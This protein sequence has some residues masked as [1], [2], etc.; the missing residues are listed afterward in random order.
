MKKAMLAVSFMVLC[1]GA[2]FAAETKIERANCDITLGR[3]FP[4]AKGTLNA[5]DDGNV[6]FDYDFANGGRYVGVEIKLPAANMKEFSINFE[7]KEKGMRASLILIQKNGRI[8]TRR[9]HY[10]TADKIVINSDTVFTKPGAEVNGS[11]NKVLFRIEKSDNAPAKG[12]VIFK[13]ITF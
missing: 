8:E 2:V 10:G 5:D 13:N 4:G 6:I 9:K 7:T 3:E 1:A 11:A 12:T